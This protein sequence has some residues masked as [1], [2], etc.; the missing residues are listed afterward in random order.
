MS[1]TRYPGD[2]LYGQIARD[3]LKLEGVWPR[4]PRMNKPVYITSE[5]LRILPLLMTPHLTSGGSR[6]KPPREQYFCQKRLLF[7]YSIGACALRLGLG[8]RAEGVC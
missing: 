4:S 2:G 3:F 6:F 7:I 8:L 1:K 5:D